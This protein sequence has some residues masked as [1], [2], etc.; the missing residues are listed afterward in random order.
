MPGRRDCFVTGRGRI[1]HR[2]EIMISVPRV[3]C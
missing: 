2:H 1:Q 3:T